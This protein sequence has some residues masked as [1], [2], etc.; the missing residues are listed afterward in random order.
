MQCLHQHHNRTLT[1]HSLMP[2]M[3]NSEMS[4]FATVHQQTDSSLNGLS[5]DFNHYLDDINRKSNAW[6]SIVFTA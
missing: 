1:L 6:S 4:H 3:C 2:D 5:Q